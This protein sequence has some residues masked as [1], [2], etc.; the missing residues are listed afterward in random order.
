[1]RFGSV[2]V[3]ETVSVSGRLGVKGNFETQ[4]WKF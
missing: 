4:I 1:M 2:K 3:L